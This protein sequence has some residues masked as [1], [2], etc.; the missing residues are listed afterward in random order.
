MKAN[1]RCIKCLL[2][3]QIKRVEKHNDEKLKRLFLSDV[4]NEL[5]NHSEDESAPLL[6]KRID[7]AYKKYFGNID[8]YKDAKIQYNRFLLE[9]EEAL[10][11]LIL[12]ASDPIKECIKYVCAANYIDFSAVG[13]VNEE[14]FLQLLEKVKTQ[15]I[16]EEEYRFFKTDLHNATSLVYLTDNCGEIVIDKIFIKLI[17]ENFKNLNTV[18]ILRGQN[19]L[20]DA[21][22]Q[23]AEQ[24]GLTKVSKCIG[25]GNS[26]PGTILELLSP[27]AKDLILNADI[28]IAK[29][30]GNFESLF[31][32]GL[33]PY[34][35]FLCKCDLFT[36]RFG[37]EKFS[38]V[39]K[40]EERI[41]K[42]II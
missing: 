1:E 19:T 7:D 14:T 8:E 42:L 39:F 30:Q 25:N 32:E 18:V 37:L 40:K 38:Q 4:Q 5:I 9:K 10:E 6:N 41:G 16:D 11:K 36:D 21:T 27:E 34:Y 15:S 24:I 20:N 28:I 31:K 3:K 22:M 35:L 17:K 23:D 13:N 29:G 12:E 2:N 26:A 33:N